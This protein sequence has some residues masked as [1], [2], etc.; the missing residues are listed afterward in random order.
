MSYIEEP[1]KHRCRLTLGL[2]SQAP[3]IIIISTGEKAMPSGLGV[4]QTQWE[5]YVAAT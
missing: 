5:N 3:G 2:K 4:Y 1:L